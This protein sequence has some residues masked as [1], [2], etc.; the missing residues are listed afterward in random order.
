MSTSYEHT[1]WYAYTSSSQTMRTWA[2]QINAAEEIPEA[3]QAIF[4]QVDGSFPYTIF[5]PEEKQTKFQQR[6]SQI[7]SVFGD[8][9]VL[10]E[11]VDNE[12]TTLSSP[13]TNVLTVEHGVILLKS[14]LKIETLAGIFNLKFNTTNDYL[15]IPIIE[16]IRQKVSPSPY[17][18]NPFAE[19]PDLTKFDF[20]ENINFKFRNFGKRSVRKH[21]SILAVVYEPEH[22]LQAFR[23]L[24][25]TLF[26][27]YKTDFLLTLTTAEL[28][29]IKEDKQIRTNIDPAYGRVSIYIP[30]RQILDITFTSQA[31]SAFWTMAV[32]LPNNVTL[33]CDLS[34]GNDGL[35]LLRESATHLG[36]VSHFN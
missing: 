25:K 29:L 7:I 27:R 33:T 24:R 8:H 36:G 19:K 1:K 15:F 34:E 28:I 3:F 35:A 2:R 6:N 32:M 16:T 13:F 22:S 11:Q 21:D 31:E 10:W 12:I 14:W 30:R 17:Q 23:L 26:R 18:E 20:L 4:P 9:F 5:I